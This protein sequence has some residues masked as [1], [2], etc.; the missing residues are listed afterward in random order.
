MIERVS[1]NSNGLPVAALLI[2]MGLL[3]IV[4]RFQLTDYS[5]RLAGRNRTPE[6]RRR[7]ANLAFLT[8]ACA[9]V[10]ALAAVFVI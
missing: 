6:Q 4:F 1:M 7:H 3:V 5:D 9:F 2:T 8:A 10:L